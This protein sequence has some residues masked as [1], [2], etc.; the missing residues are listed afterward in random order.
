[1]ACR[2]PQTM[3]VAQKNSTN[4]GLITYM[5]TDSV[6]LSSQAI[7]AAKQEITELF[8]EKYSAPRNFKTKTKGAQEAHEAIRPS[9]INRR[10]IDGS[11]SEKRLYEL[12]WKRTVAS[13][14][15]AAQIDRSI[16]TI[17]VSGSREQ[18]T[19]TGEVVLFDGF[20]K[21]YSESTEDESGENSQGIMPKMQVG[22]A[23]TANSI[24]ATQRFTQSPARYNEAMLVK[25][26]EE[27]GIGRPSTYAPTISTIINRGYVI[28][29]NK[30][31]VKREYTVLTLKRQNRRKDGEREGRQGGRQTRPTDA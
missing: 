27:L 17:D 22:D 20:L 1:M 21:L 30:D 18:F 16:V 13:Q 11:A 23:L 24:T 5:R 8:G 29:Q 12:I 9:Y 15:A 25:R 7:Q 28:K 19:A 10:E 3:S 6:N 26:L 4:R 2:C 14:M 31:G